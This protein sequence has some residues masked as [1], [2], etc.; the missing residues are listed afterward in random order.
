MY[1]MYSPQRREAKKNVLP[2]IDEVVCRGKGGK[3]LVSLQAAKFAN[4]QG[5]R[6]ERKIGI[7]PLSTTF[8]H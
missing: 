7:P 6:R 2:S 3:M 8:P 1:F 4:L 5:W